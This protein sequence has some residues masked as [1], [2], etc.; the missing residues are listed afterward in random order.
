MGDWFRRRRRAI[1]RCLMLN[2]LCRN[3]KRAWR[4][5]LFIWG[6]WALPFCLCAS[7]SF[8]VCYNSSLTLIL[9]MTSQYWVLIIISWFSL[10]NL[11]FFLSWLRNPGHLIK[12]NKVSFLKLVEKFDP[13][14]LCPTCEVICTSES[15]HCYICN[16]CVE[17]FDHHC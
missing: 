13:N 15:R 12:S 8:H 2:N 4:L 9:D 7:S 11:F 16:K 3:W 5:Y 17:R 10:T 6:W 14:M 1:A